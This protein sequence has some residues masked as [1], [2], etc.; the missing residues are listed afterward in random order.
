MS[1]ESPN[2][3]DL[4]VTLSSI[5]T[6]LDSID[7]VVYVS[8]MET[9]ELI[10]I[11]KYGRDIW[12]EPNGR[13]CWQVLQSGQTG[14]CEFCTNDRLV[15]ADNNPTGAYVWEFQNTVDNHWY[16]CR[17]QAIPWIDG[18]LVRLEIASDITDRKQIEDEL[19][20][21]KSKYVKLAR[22]DELTGIINRRGFFEE[23]NKICNLAKRFNHTT[24]IIMLDIDYFKQVNDEHGHSAGDKALVQ[25]VETIRKNIREVDIFARLGG[26]EFAIVL[27]E[28]DKNGAIKI[29]EKLCAKTA[30]MVIPTE[31][32]PLSITCSFGVTSFRCVTTSF[33]EALSHADKALYQAKSEGRNQVI[34]GK[35]D[36][37]D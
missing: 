9:Y 12:G 21:S 14:P 30:A 7:A 10:Y 25:F 28:T 3:E 1:D 26:E 6:I 19:K 17:D 36:T 11:N 2:I 32:A 35:E 29:A 22:T 24:S 23:G 37:V 33:E 5:S 13:R 34:Y 15:D 8:D 27:P 4:D 20:A 18:R 16:Q 31:G